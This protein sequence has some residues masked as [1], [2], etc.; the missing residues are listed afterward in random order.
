MC[1]WRAAP[2]EDIEPEC[3]ARGSKVLQMLHSLSLPL[4]AVLEIGCGTGWLTDKLAQLGNVTA[5][6]LSEKAIAIAQQRNTGAT[7]IAGNIYTQDFGAQQFDIVVCVET[8][9]CVADQHLFIAKLASLT[10]P[11]GYLVVTAQN[12]FVYQRRS[13]IGPPR[14]GQI[15]QWLSRF[16]LHRLLQSDFRILK[17]VTVLPRGDRGILRLVNSYKLNWVLN[18]LFSKGRIDRVKEKLGFGHSRV[19]LAERRDT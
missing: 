18:R 14:A 11:G 15:R 5:I 1:R 10:K 3:K 4:P 12:K 6:D 7:F 17:S 16:E 13:D 19:V 2:F 8:L 9:S